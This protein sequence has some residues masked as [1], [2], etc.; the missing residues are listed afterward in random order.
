MKKKIDILCT[1]GPATLN[2]QFLKYSTKNISLLRLNMSHLSIDQ[3]KKN[4]KY[5]KKY[6]KTPICID[7]EGAQIR[8]KI[9]K[10]I[11]LK[12]GKN[13]K[14]YKNN[15]FFLYPEIIFFKLKPGD[16]L[17]FGF[18]SLKI[19]LLNKR[20]DFFNCR[21]ISQGYLENNKGVHVC[22]R[23]IKI[24]F[25]T[26]K[27]FKAIEIGLKNKIKF[28]ALSFTSSGKDIQKF[29]KILPFQT[30]IFKIE[31]A[32][33]I[34][35][36]EKILKAGKNFLIDRG[37]LS[38]DISIE[39]LPLVQRKICRLGKKYKKN[40]F[41]A[42]NFLESMIENNYPTR[43]EVNDIY[44]TLEMGVKGLVLA[45]ETAIGKYP[46]QS[47]ILLKKII[48]VYKLNNLND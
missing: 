22:N 19:K 21:V 1:I 40:I 7:T 28:F 38:K 16:I 14:I 15:F 25:L 8:T 33:A 34:T 9:K 39:N 48:K 4:I 44:N 32:L 26:D 36:L 23:K 24:N 2:K 11:F 12:L 29:N 47:V 46:I 30:K 43:G 27:D 45:A 31:T 13:I 20:K 3:L 17:D 37:D 42:T 35:N 18:K 41:V 6:T 10:S 5:I